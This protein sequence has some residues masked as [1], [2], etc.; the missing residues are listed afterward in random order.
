MDEQEKDRKNELMQRANVHYKNKDLLGLLGLQFEIEQTNQSHLDNL[1][2]DK[3]VIYNRLLQKKLQ[4]TTQ[5]IALIK[6]KISAEFDIPYYAIKPEEFYYFLNNQ[7]NHLEEQKASLIEDLA[8]F[9]DP[10]HFK[11]FLNNIRI[12]QL[13]DEIYSPEEDVFCF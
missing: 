5:D 4:K 13:R 8:T 1:S 11:K 2:N 7:K 9:N 10:K 3:L 6:Q 12:N